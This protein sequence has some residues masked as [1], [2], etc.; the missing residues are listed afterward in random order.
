MNYTISQAAKKM[1]LTIY[2]LRYY[3]R[4]GLLSNVER[5][6]SGKRIFTKDSMEMLALIS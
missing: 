1:N 5:D 6:K 4:E 2:T 3:D